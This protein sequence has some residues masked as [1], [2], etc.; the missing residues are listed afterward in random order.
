MGS[1]RERGRVREKLY[2]EGGSSKGVAARVNWAEQ[3][4][5]SA[6]SKKGKNVQLNV[7]RQKVRF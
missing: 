7:I 3:N 4:N 1:G 6:N 2:V 5:P